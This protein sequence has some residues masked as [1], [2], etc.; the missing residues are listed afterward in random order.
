MRCLTQPKSVISILRRCWRRIRCAGLAPRGGVVSSRPAPRPVLSPRLSTPRSSFLRPFVT[1]SSP[2]A[3]LWTPP[4]P[5]PTWVGS[6]RRRCA[7]CAAA[8][9]AS[10]S[11]T[12]PGTTTPHMRA[13]RLAPHPDTPPPPRSCPLTTSW[14]CRCGWWRRCRSATS[15]TP[16]CR[17]PTASATGGERT[18]A[19]RASTSRARPT[20]TTSACA[21]AACAAPLGGEEGSGGVEGCRP[22]QGSGHARLATGVGAAGASVQRRARQGATHLAVTAAPARPPSAAGSTPRAARSCP[23]F[24]AP[25]L[26][27]ATRACSAAACARW[28]AR[29]CSTCW[30]SSTRRSGSVSARARGRRA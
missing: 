18:R 2:W 4:A 23:A 17:G 24:C 9:S 19:R 15:W 7:A 21:A 6:A 8:A 12:P 11:G 22:L 1:P 5:R 13:S 29:C 20:F 14:T 3:R 27:S 25:R 16:T 10:S 30:G 26:Q 28:T